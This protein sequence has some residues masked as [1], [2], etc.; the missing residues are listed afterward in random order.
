MGYWTEVRIAT[1]DH[2]IRH[3]G[4]CGY[5]H[6]R[7]VR[8]TTDVWVRLLYTYTPAPTAEAPRVRFGQFQGHL[9]FGNYE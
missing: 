7:G 5:L 9:R 8:S 6:V 1:R 4:W 2:T 3:V